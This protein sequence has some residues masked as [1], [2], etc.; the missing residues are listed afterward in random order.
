MIVDTSALVAI[1]LR[2]PGYVEMIDALAE[3][4]NVIPAPVL[5]EF[6]RVVMRKPA[7]LDEAHTMVELLLAANTSVAS[8][9][10]EVAQQA[11]AANVRYGIGNGVGGTLNML[12]LMVYATARHHRLP[13]LCT[14]M[15]FA[16][17]DAK[18]HPASR[19]G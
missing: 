14:G 6:D 3:E 5:I 18:I 7:N 16:A 17:T 15:D 12:D 1:F 10:H 4:P 11:V 19:M 9:D 8:F 2:E 13:I